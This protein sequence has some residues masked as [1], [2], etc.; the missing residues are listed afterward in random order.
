MK[1]TDLKSCSCA[2]QRS[3]GILGTRWKPVIIYTL[4][5]R[6]ARFGQLDALIEHI[7]RKVLTSSLKEL[8]E[9]GVIFREEFKELPPRVEYSLTEKGKALIP[10]M[11][12]L[13]K[14]NEEYHE[15][16][17]MEMV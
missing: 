4:R 3:M 13:A 15:K 8:E 16:P 14:W 7:S 12:Q 10:I 5:D 2:M 6:K 11:C 17:E 9:D 1:R